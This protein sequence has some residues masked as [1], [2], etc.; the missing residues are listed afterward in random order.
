MFNLNAIKL[1][2]LN[3]NQNRIYNIE[4]QVKHHLEESVTQIQKA[5]YSTGKQSRSLQYVKVR[6]KDKS[7]E[8]HSKLGVEIST[9][10]L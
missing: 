3:S 8:I 2:K 9:L 4:K 7:G 10:K 6:E 5:R 1:L